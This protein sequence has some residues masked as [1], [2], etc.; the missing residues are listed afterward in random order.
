M[1]TYLFVLLVSVVTIVADQE[2]MDLPGFKMVALEG[3]EVY[4]FAISES[5]ATVFIFMR[6]DCP[7][8]NRY[9]PEIRRLHES[10]SSEIAFF[11]VYL[12][13]EQSSEI[14]LKHLADYDLSV[15]ALRDPMH[16]LVALTKA[17]VTP[18]AV[19]FNEKRDQVYRGRIDDRFVTFGITRPSPNQR[20]L[21]K[22]LQE[23]L[24]GEEVKPRTTQAIGCYISD[25][26]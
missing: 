15:R 22:I 12:D 1:A 4:P 14:V 17:E 9:I 11:L 26:W 2:K 6:T 7:I 5:R 10:F 24:S 23:I 19:V 16:Q 3:H 25:L 18:E 13:Q 8:S 21:R 20:D